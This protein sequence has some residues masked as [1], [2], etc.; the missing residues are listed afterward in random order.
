[1][2]SLVMVTHTQLTMM[3]R[4]LRELAIEKGEVED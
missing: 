1:M 3:K 4:V 2:G